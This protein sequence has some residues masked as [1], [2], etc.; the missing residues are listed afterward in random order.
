MSKSLRGGWHTC[1]SVE[2][3]TAGAVCAFAGG[4]LLGLLLGRRR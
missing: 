3:L 4:I 1:P 2:E